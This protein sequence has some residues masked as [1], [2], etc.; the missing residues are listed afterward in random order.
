MDSGFMFTYA[1]GSFIT[2]MLGDRFSPVGVVAGGL[3]GSTIC[4][5]L[6]VFGAST[7]IIGNAAICG[8]W[9]LTCQMLHGAF[10]ATGGPVRTFRLIYSSTKFYP[11]VLVGQHCHHG[12]LVRLARSWP[13]IRLMDMPSIYRRHRRCVLFSLRDPL[14]LR[15]ALVHCSARRH[16]RYLGH[17]QLVL[18]PQQPSRGRVSSNF[19]QC[20]SN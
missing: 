2:G 11:I 4:L 20:I 3:F 14:G 13:S 6:I 19:V 17:R 7:S 9:F 8:S 1:G 12:Q 16:Q 15:L 18:R 5:L 10:Q